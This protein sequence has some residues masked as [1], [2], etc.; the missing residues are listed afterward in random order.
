MA[1]HALAD[2]QNHVIGWLQWEQSSLGDGALVRFPRIWMSS[3]ECR[4]KTV[5]RVLHYDSEKIPPSLRDQLLA[6][7]KQ[8]VGGDYPSHMRRYVGLNLLEDSFSESGANVDQIGAHIDRLVFDSLRRPEA[9]AQE[10][11]WL[12][13]ERANNGFRFG[14]ALGR[15]DASNSQW[16]TILRALQESTERSGIFVG[17]YLA[18][19]FERRPADWEVM[20][21][22]LEADPSTRDL[23]LEC[24]WRSGLSDRAIGRILKLVEK[25]AIA[26]ERLK[27]LSG[28]RVAKDMSPVSFAAVT[29]ALLDQQTYK[30]GNAALH[31]VEMRLHG[32]K[33]PNAVPDSLLE[34]ILFNPVLLKGQER[35]GGNDDFQW[36]ELAKRYAKHDEKR[37]ERII[38]YGLSNFHRS[39][40]IFDYGSGAEK[41]LN[42]LIETF[43]LAGWKI[44]SAYLGAPEYQERYWIADWLSGESDWDSSP[45]GG[46][47]KAFPAEEIWK[48]AD[49]DRERRTGDTRLCYSEGFS[50]PAGPVAV[51]RRSTTVRER[52]Q[53]AERTCGQLLHGRLVWA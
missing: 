14:Q 18:G 4:L 13:P 51:V 6:I 12:V 42:E 46:P 48:W 45:G 44:V 43:P 47:F 7:R 15:A 20:L 17:G 39:D 49:A 52:P 35:G 24:T 53:R 9:L 8:L 33:D 11:F 5:E 38:E 25:G 21:D 50:R 23:V 1:C 22:E 37:A 41:V 40:S 32:N 16:K 27:L 30:A 34:G 3:G 10:I 19:V 28:G 36:A 2:Y 29:N 26:P 31:I